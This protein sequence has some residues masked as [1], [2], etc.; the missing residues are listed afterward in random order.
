M[1]SSRVLAIS[2]ESQVLDVSGSPTNRRPARRPGLVREPER[3]VPLLNASSDMRYS[4]GCAA[5]MVEVVDAGTSTEA[6]ARRVIRVGRS[7]PLN[8]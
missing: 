8:G 4:S 1:Y 6:V 5:P 7:M 2:G 3:V